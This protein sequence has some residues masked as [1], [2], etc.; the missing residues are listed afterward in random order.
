MRT[1]CRGSLSSLL[2]SIA[3]H[4]SGFCLLLVVPHKPSAQLQLP[5]EQPDAWL[6]NAVEVDAIETSDVTPDAARAS[7]LAESESPPSVPSP[8]LGRGQSP[9]AAPSAELGPAKS[10][11]LEPKP[12][13]RHSAS[14]ATISAS[15][16][17]AAKPSAAST[18]ASSAANTGAFGSQGLPPGVRNLPSALTRAIPTATS[19]DPIWQALPAGPQRAFTLA[20]QVDS[21]GHIGAAEIV[22]PSAG[23]GI[24]TEV[25]HFQQ[26][27][28]ALL[29]GG[30]FA[31]Q[32]D[33]A[34]GRDVFRITIT[35]SDRAVSE[36][37]APAEL[38]E[39]GFEP[40]RGKSPGRA[41]FT[42]ASGRH[43][44]AKVEVLNAP[45]HPMRP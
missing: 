3:L 25:A 8:E 34:A 12:R 35:L 14:P 30:L 10:I 43:F 38:V 11:Q 2:G 31:L 4:A 32:N 5:R 37:S 41:Y 45:P 28:I 19:A 22:E 26:R 18:A 39:R 42:L 44:E 15:G 29:G 9:A 27:V 17:R 6:G 13:P 36:D 7:S 33:S 23:S 21:E 16:L 1:A 24:P 20:V 40:P